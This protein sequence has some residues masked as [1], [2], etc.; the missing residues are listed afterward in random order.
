MVDRTGHTALGS[1]ARAHIAEVPSPVDR[2]HTRPSPFGVLAEL[3]T[4]NVLIT[5]AT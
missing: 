3:T 5:A 4:G 2:G 1:R